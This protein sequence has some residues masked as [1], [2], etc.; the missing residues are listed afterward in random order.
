MGLAVRLYL[1]DDPDHMMPMKI[2]NQAHERKGKMKSFTSYCGGLPSPEAA[3]NPLAYK[4]LECGPHS[5]FGGPNS[6]STACVAIIRGK[7]LV[8]ANARDSR[9]V[10]SR[11]GQ[12]HNLSKDHKPGLEAEKDRILKASGFI[13]VGRVNGSLNLAI[14]IGTQ[15]HR[16]KT[17]HPSRKQSEGTWT[18]GSTPSSVDRFV[19]KQ[20]AGRTDEGGAAI[21]PQICPGPLIKPRKL[22]T[23]KRCQAQ[24]TSREEPLDEK[25]QDEGNGTLRCH[26][27]PGTKLHVNNSPLFLGKRARSRPTH[28]TARKIIKIKVHQEQRPRQKKRAKLPGGKPTKGVAQKLEFDPL[29]IPQRRVTKAKIRVKIKSPLG[30]SQIRK[31]RQ[32]LG[33]PQK[34][35]SSISS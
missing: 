17:K 6:G 12:A 29:R 8:V 20:I 34:A 23:L 27:T 3:N 31:P 1:F 19:S 30:I 4:F 22:R 25:V 21:D 10:L 35:P 18:N 14:A 32:K 16:Q 11:K 33:L 13:Q 7:K 24:G 2:I 26:V 28:T 15:I 9:C 5:D